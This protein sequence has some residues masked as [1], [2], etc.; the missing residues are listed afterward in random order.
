LVL[1]GLFTVSSGNIGNGIQHG[2]SFA[3]ES[4]W[5]GFERVDF[6]KIGS[7]KITLPIFANCEHAVKIRVYDG[8]PGQ[9][10]HLVG[11]FIYHKKS[12]WLT[13]IPETYH[14]TRVLKGL[15]TIVLESGD[16][17]DVQ[18]F[19]FEKRKREFIEISAIECEKL[20]GDQYTVEED[21][22]TGI[23]N[24]V[25]LEFG[26][27]D[28]GAQTP[29]AL[30]IAGRSRQSHGSIHMIFEGTKSRRM[31]LEFEGSE[32]YLSKTFPVEGI[33]G[34][35]RVSFVF[36]PGSCFDFRSFRFLSAYTEGR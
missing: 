17:F 33:S 23:G 27:F 8:I 10:G 1:G 14:L 25:L 12:E 21:A 15:H 3:N 19:L 34:R 22:V 9:D 18:C 26:E 36:M 5:F 4:S 31:I 24:N 6:G 16:G 29:Q 11:D 28:F 7:H 32:E 30:E 20:Y 35:G 13:Y 2:S